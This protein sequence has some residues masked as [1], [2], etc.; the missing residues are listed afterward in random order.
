[1]RS[2]ETHFISVSANNCVKVFEE[3]RSERRKGEGASEQSPLT[4][5]LPQVWLRLQTAVS[6]PGRND[7]Q[8]GKRNLAVL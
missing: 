7:R 4:S 5:L 1:M 3:C 6:D 2:C 8:G